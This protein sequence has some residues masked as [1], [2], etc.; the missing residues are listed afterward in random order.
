MPLI[1][2]SIP[3]L[4]GGVSQQ[5]PSIRRINQCEEMINAFPSPVEGLVKRPPSSAWFHLRDASSNIYT[6][7]TDSN[8]KPHF[9]SRDATEKYFVSVHPTASSTTCAIRVYDSTGTAKTVK[10]DTGSRDYLVNATRSGLKLLTVAD[11]TFITNTAKVPELAVKKTD[12]VNY[13]RI[14]LVY[15]KQSGD[16]RETE[17]TVSDTGGTNSFTV[18]HKTL[19]ANAGT[20]HVAETLATA[21]N[22]QNPGSVTNGTYTATSSDS[23]IKI[24][25]NID[26]KITVDDDFGGTGAV[27]IRES[28][29]RFEDLPAAA[30]HNHIVKVV[31]VP[32]SQIDD[33]Y[34]KFSCVDGSGFTKGVWQE[35]LSPDIEYEYD[36]STMPHILIRQSDGTFLFKW[37]DGQTPSSP[38]APSGS[39]YSAYKWTSRLV[40]DDLTNSAPSFVGIPITNMVLYKNRL[41]FL[42]DENII[43]SESSEFFNFW[44]TTVLDIPDSDPIDIASSSPKI[45]KM[46]SGIVF[47][48]D[49]I[50]FTDNSQLVL[51]GGD[52][53]SPKAVSL[54]PVGDYEAYS[55]INPISSGLSVFF[56]YDRGGGYSGVRE[57]VPQENIDGSYT[58]N[59]VSLDIPSYI[60]GKII[61]IASTTQDDVVAFVAS[62]NL[63]LYKF[64]KSAE[65]VVQSAWFKYNFP[66]TAS[67]G[68][69]T[70]LWAEFVDTELYVLLARSSSSIPVVEKIKIGVNLTDA[71]VVNNSNW[72]SH[73][74]AR[75]LKASGTGTYSSATGLTTWNLAKPYSY[76]SGNHAVYTTSGASL[77]VTGGTAYNTSSDAAGT[78]SVSGDYSG[79]AVWIGYRYEMLYQ[80]SQFWLQGG[81]GRNQTS[82]AALQS[83]RYQLKNL[84]VIYD[85]TSFF[86]ATINVGGE[87][88]YEYLYSG[89]IVGSSVLNQIYLNRGSFRIPIYGRNLTTTVTITNDTALPCKLLS[90]EIEGDYVDRAQRYS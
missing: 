59:T 47:N 29:Q 5:A 44:R 58:V 51:R 36:Y 13:D 19:N 32:E 41:G 85:D 43:L 60:K 8:I 26:F 31:G 21:L 76:K 35:T 64:T 10:Y 86:K 46:K 34:V 88:N 33:Y 42:S 89:L 23:V 69:A 70:V 77:R 25:R 66:D 81:A 84:S 48:K 1:T 22:G 27:L 65:G 63:Y 54:L 53:L 6:G 38:T 15:I 20:D 3:N 72:V 56:G 79:T 18:S 16:N 67:S 14:A 90:A 52:I 7:A 57:L 68:F 28:V 12:P 80:F 45:G 78:I 55:D 39:D 37:A 4:I 30:P 17:I 83:G 24:T 73:L 71:D 74:D 11:V 50:L 40:G 2:Q 75:E 49:L 9:I 82:S 61:H 62:E 87:D